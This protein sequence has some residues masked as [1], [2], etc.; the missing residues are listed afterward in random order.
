MTAKSYNKEVS[1]FQQQWPSSVRKKNYKKNVEE[2]N[3]YKKFMIG[4][5][6]MQ[7]NFT[8]FESLK[9]KM[10]KLLVGSIYHDM[11]LGQF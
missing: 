8:R 11:L 10:T 1:L 4:N 5:L 6:L 7:T 9:V 3:N 2:L